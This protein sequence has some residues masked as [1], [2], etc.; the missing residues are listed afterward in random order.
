MEIYQ[1][2]NRVNGKSYI[3]QTAYKAKYRTTSLAK[4]KYLK[5]DIE[6]YGEDAFEVVVLEKDIPNTKESK[7]RALHYAAHLGTYY[8][9]G[10]NIRVCGEVAVSTRKIT[11]AGVEWKPLLK[12]WEAYYITKCHKR[13]L[14]FF[15]KECDA[16]NAIDK[17]TQAR[18]KVTPKPVK[19]PISYYTQE[20]PLKYFKRQ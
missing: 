8:P 3:G 11:S 1:I 16:L 4:N 14:D 2:V 15:I 13:T 7:V 6:K 17:V 5:R 12:M 20:D 18:Y 19:H 9:F 10:Y